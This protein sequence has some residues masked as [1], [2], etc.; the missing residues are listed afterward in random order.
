MNR[1]P[2]MHISEMTAPSV[3]VSPSLSLQSTEPT[4]SSIDPLIIRNIIDEAFHVKTDKQ[5]RVT[6]SLKQIGYELF[7]RR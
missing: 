5:G 1:F 3:T 4:F 2:M 6:P 7:V